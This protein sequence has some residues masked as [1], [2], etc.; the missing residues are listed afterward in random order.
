M[1]LAEAF[2]LLQETPTEGPS[3]SVALACGFTPLHMQTFLTAHLSLAL[4]GLALGGLA[5][6]RGLA[7]GDLALGDLALGGLALGGSAL[8]GLAFGGPAHPRRRVD[9]RTGPFGDLAGTLERLSG[10]AH[11]VAIV[12]EWSDLDP[13]L[14]YRSLGGW[15]RAEQSDIFPTVRA[16]LD[17]LRRAIGQIQVS[18]PASTPVALSLPSLPMAPAFHTTGWQVSAEEFLVRRELMNFAVE[19]A[20]Q[21]SVRLV[22]ESRLPAAGRFD[23]RAELLTGCPYTPAHADA[24]SEALA[25]LIQP[26]PVKKGLITDLDGTLW[27]GI[28]G[29]IGPHRVSWDLASH[30]QLH[31]LYQQLLQ[32]LAGEGVLIAAASKNDPATVEQALGRSDLQFRGLF[33]VEA[34]WEA[35]SNSVAR[36]LETWNVGADSVVFIDDSPMELAEVKAAWPEIECLLFPAEDH[37]AADA[38]FRRLRDLF[39]KGRLS[40][41][42]SLRMASIRG[43]ADVRAQAGR[44]GDD[45]DRFLSEARARMSIE[46]DP[47]AEDARVPELV[48]K[49]H[50]FNLNG[51][52]YTA[53]TDSP[54]AFVMAVSYQDRFG[55]LGKIAVIRGHDRNGA[56]EIGTWAMSCRAFSRRIEHRCL[57]I[58]FDRFGAAEIHLQFAA[59]SRNSRF[60]EMLELYV[61]GTPDGAISISRQRFAERAPKLYH[62]VEFVQ[63]SRRAASMRSQ[64]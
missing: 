4:G 30:A 61:G 5:P 58:L 43:A 6:D 33:P 14:G 53:L 17:R 37:A 56:V 52:P 48:N 63:N 28:A 3:F 50:Q 47:P 24:L 32:A 11:A 55:P 51:R 10:E 7:L 31:G 12:I 9:V 62:E 21:P 27:R 46:F 45:Q 19:V 1:K 13:R 59:T 16:A 22:N 36:I 20:R 15:G 42:D 23:L 40:E 8:D 26:R 44:P 34:H 25:R 18:L 39:G 54:G 57:E 60:R 41:E 35:K 29:E 64:A 49:T 2:E 38:L